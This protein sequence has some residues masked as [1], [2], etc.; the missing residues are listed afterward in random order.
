MPEYM[1]GSDL[2]D[3]EFDDAGAVDG[4][5]NGADRVKLPS[6]NGARDSKQNRITLPTFSKL[7]TLPGKQEIRPPYPVVPRQAC[8]EER[9][10]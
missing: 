2:R 1:D 10:S 4:R 5:S 3:T 6:K 9:I 7:G 8:S